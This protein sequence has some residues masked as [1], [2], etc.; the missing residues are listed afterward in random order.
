MKKLLSVLL[1]F[2]F[3]FPMA[4]GQTTVTFPPGKLASEA[5]VRSYVDSVLKAAPVVKLPPVI[6]STPEEPVLLPCK[7][8]PEIRSIS[9]VTEQSLVVVFHGEKVFGLDFQIS[10]SGTPR[11]TGQIEPESNTLTI[12]YETLSPG[13]YTLRLIGNT[14]QGTSEP[15]EFTIPKSVGETLPS[16]PT[17]IPDRT[18]GPQY[19]YVGRT[20]TTYLDIVLTPTDNGYLITD[21]ANFS[22]RAG[23]EYWYA[24]NNTIVKSATPLKD[25]GYASRSGVLSITKH[26]FISGLDYSARWNTSEPGN[27]WYNPNASYSWGQRSDVGGQSIILL[28]S[29]DDVAGDL[30]WLDITPAWYQG[31]HTMSWPYR[32]PANTVASGKMLGY[33]A[34]VAGI[35]SKL[36]QSRGETHITDTSLPLSQQLGRVVGCRVLGITTTTGTR[37]YYRAAADRWPLHGAAAFETNEGEVWLPHGSTQV[38]QI[39]E[40]LTERYKQAG[41]PYFLSPDYGGYGFITK[42]I[43]E[44]DHRWKY[45]ASGPEL[46]LRDEYFRS[47]GG[48]IN[49]VNVKNYGSDPVDFGR[50]IYNRLSH[51][52]IIKRAGYKAIGFTWNFLEIFQQGYAPGFAW[53]NQISGNTVLTSSLAVLPYEEAVTDGFVSMW[54]GDGLWVWDGQSTRN[55]DATTLNLSYNPAKTTLNGLRIRQDRTAFEGEFQPE[56]DAA[57]DG[58]YVGAVTLAGQCQATEGGQRRYL[59]FSIDGKYYSTEA[60]GSDVLTA[61]REK[62]GICQVRVKGNQATVFFLDPYAGLEWRNFSVSI[63]G[64][65]F[66]GK[67]FGKRPHVANIA[68]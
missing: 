28:N 31:D 32:A 54:Y 19:T 7:A 24:I 20:D 46:I 35:S 4:R 55:R 52:E 5:Y 47:Y 25:Y 61:N 59:P 67:V 8:G 18:L 27:T 33:N 60:D 44:A 62:R 9:N 15:K 30:A 57:L 68:L 64:K 26:H 53:Q 63:G 58:F 16:A 3:C 13:T 48:T 41:Y 56:P 17:P 21:R 23:Y 1:L 51:Y 65:T 45:S 42:P 22:L 43:W 12:G 40:R 34:S 11:R 36:R 50:S 49:T 39:M 6:P 38:R 29:D 37:D 10:Q 14:C 2:A 66:T